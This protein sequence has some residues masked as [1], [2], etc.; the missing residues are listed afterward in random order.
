MLEG[1]ERRNH[2][3]SIRPNVEKIG[4]SRYRKNSINDII[5]NNACK[6]F[7]ENYIFVRSNS[8]FLLRRL[9]H[10][11]VILASMNDY[12]DNENNSQDNDCDSDEDYKEDI[13]INKW[14][15]LLTEEQYQS[16]ER[17]DQ[18]VVGYL[19]L[20][21]RQSKSY[22]ENHV[23]Y[24]AD[25]D[26]RVGGCNIVEYMIRKVKKELED[27]LNM[28]Q[29]YL[30]P[31]TIP[32]VSSK[33]WVETLRSVYEYDIGSLEKFKDDLW[34]KFDHVEWNNLESNWYIEEGSGTNNV[35]EWINNILKLHFEEIDK[36]LVCLYVRSDFG[37]AT[38]E[39]EFLDNKYA[40]LYDVKL[41]NDFFNLLIRARNIDFFDNEGSLPNDIDPYFFRESQI[42]RICLPNCEIFKC[43]NSGL[44]YLP[45][46][47]KCVGLN[48]E[49]NILTESTFLETMNRSFGF[50]NGPIIPLPE[51]YLLSSAAIE[52]ILLNK[53]RFPLI[54]GI[55]SFLRLFPYDT[56]NSK[57]VPQPFMEDPFDA[58][59]YPPLK[60]LNALPNTNI[61]DCS[62]AK[63]RVMRNI[64]KNEIVQ[65]CTDITTKLNQ[66]YNTT[67]YSVVPD[68]GDGGL[69]FN[70]YPGMISG[71]EKSISF[72][73]I[74]DDYRNYYSIPHF[75]PKAMT[76]W[77]NDIGIA[78]GK[79]PNLTLVSR[80]Y[81]GAPVFK[82][83]EKSI[84]KE[85]LVKS[86][87][88]IIE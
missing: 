82:A 26:T 10:M 38:L 32:D 43:N 9:S 31:H 44:K 55:Q 68:K 58:N 12:E 35:E 6:E 51:E 45:N 57:V 46:L 49:S 5:D 50:Y 28:E 18:Y 71:S 70:A 48:C 80:A 81:H 3:E 54:A 75:E 53:S 60:T 72:N 41:D 37:Q 88:K 30:L 7:V 13:R 23:I 25:I 69:R 52:H 24:I 34:L 1:Y 2:F 67:E 15:Q 36:Y 56:T 11:Y 86:G 19:L 65:L 4:Q 64:S 66:L 87:F 47:R 40:T 83:G 27:E 74:Y 8:E 14:K 77:I 78:I 84:I 22:E 59:K 29:I 61:K 20:H 79:Y 85:C 62:F 39:L 73:L 42:N 17:N 21:E 16:L 76:E 33:C 63:V